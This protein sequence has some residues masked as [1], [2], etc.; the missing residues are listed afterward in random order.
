M[1]IV[2]KV[3]LQLSGDATITHAT[4]TQLVW[5]NE[6]FDASNM[7][8]TDS[9]KIIVPVDGIYKI[10]TSITW[11]TSALGYRLITLR[12]NDTESIASSSHNNVNG[13][14]ESHQCVTLMKLD[15]DDYIEV[16]VWHTHGSNL[17]IKSFSTTNF[18]LYRVN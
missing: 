15:E 11:D 7:H 8:A 1:P 12:R 5:Q 4:A 16:E 9:T 6:I 2:Q 18:W 17:K 3:R 14:R 10:G 13:T